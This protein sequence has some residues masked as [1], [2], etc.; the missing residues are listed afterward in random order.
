MSKKCKCPPTGAPEWVLTYGD[1]MSL[2]LTFFILLAAL[3]ELKK[4]QQYQAIVEQVQKSFGMQGGGGKTSSKDDPKL[5]LMQR[6]EALEMQQNK[7]K[8]I[9]NSQDPGIEGRE[10][11]VTKVREGLKFVVGGRITFEPGSADLS[12]ENRR[13]LSLVAQYM[14][15]LNNKLEIRGHAASMELT[16]GTP[17]KD[18]WGLSYARAKAVMDYLTSKEVGIRADRVRLIAVADREPLVKRVYTAQ[19]Q[20]PNRRAEI[21]VSESLVEDFTQLES[22]AGN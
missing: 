8:H 11:A 1:L 12:D 13:Q 6:L 19:R 5:T 20:E 21:M 18:L 9:S 15:G 2:L 22:N 7:E 3:S 14:R 4:D 17:F 10:P 16:E